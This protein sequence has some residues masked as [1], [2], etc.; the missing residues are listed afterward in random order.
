MLREGEPCMDMRE[1]LKRLEDRKGRVLE[2]GGPER[3]S[4][5][6]E[7]GKMTAGERLDYLLDEGSLLEYG[8][9]ATQMG[10]P[11]RDLVPADAVITGT[12]KIDGRPV[13]VISYD[14]TVKGGSIGR[15][16]DAKCRRIRELALK[17]RIP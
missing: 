6:K 7:R 13:A 15:V 1:E 16:G 2:M 17:H 11:R 4:R 8:M 5:Q 9:H 10:T 12:G 3:I 14:F